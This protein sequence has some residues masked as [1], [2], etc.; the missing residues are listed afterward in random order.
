ML[1]PSKSSVVDGQVTTKVDT[2]APIAQWKQESAY[3]T[4]AACQ[5]GIAGFANMKGMA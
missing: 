1:P 2:D 4:A 3:D 5:A